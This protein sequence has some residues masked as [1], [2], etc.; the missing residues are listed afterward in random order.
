MEMDEHPYSVAPA[1]AGSLFL[2]IRWLTPPANFRLSLR[3]TMDAQHLGKRHSG[4][5]DWRVAPAT[6]VAVRKELSDAAHGTRRESMHR[7]YGATNGGACMVAP[8]TRRLAFFLLSVGF[9]TLHPRLP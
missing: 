4:R 3:A 7:V 5:N 2:M 6:T 1:G 8:T 9:T